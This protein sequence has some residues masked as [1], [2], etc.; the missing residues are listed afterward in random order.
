MFLKLILFLMLL[1]SG[2]SCFA[3]FRIWGFR[4]DALCLWF[5]S[6]GISWQV[7]VRERSSSS[8]NTGLHLLLSVARQGVCVS[9]MN[10]IIK[11]NVAEAHVHI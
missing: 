2:N 10:L 4:Y 11:L 6:A 1:R 8:A 3:C 7:N 5:I 9:V